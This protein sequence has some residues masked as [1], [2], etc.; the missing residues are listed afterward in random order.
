MESKKKVLQPII[1]FVVTT[2][3]IV[4]FFPHE[5][6]FLFQ[7]NEGKPWRY[8]T[9]MA[10]INVPIYKTDDEI[11]AEKDSMKRMFQP[12][13]QIDMAAIAKQTE[14]LQADYP[15]S[16]EGSSY[17]DEYVIY[18]ETQLKRVYEKGIIPVQ[19]LENLKK[20]G[21]QTISL[22]KNN[23]A[24]TKNVADLY[25]V[26]TAYE[27]IIDNAPARLDKQI[28]KT[29]NINRYLT[30]NVQ[31]DKD[32]SDK[33]LNEQLQNIALSV[34]I[35]QAGERIVD[36]GEIID[37]QTYRVLRS[38]KV[39]HETK[40]GGA[41]RQNMVWF[42]EWILIFGIM[43][44]G[45]FYIATFCPDIFYNRRNLI[46]TLS[47]I[48][49]FCLLSEICTQ[50]AIINI[51]VLPLAIVPIMVR[52]FF[53]SHKAL[54][55]HLITVMLCSLV[56][57]F[58]Y[59]FLLLQ[60]I[61]GIVVLFSLKE[62][63]QRSQ[64]LRC[65]FFI[66]ITY[67]VCYLCL[68][69]YQEGDLNKV[70]WTMLLFFGLNFILSML[71]Y[72]FIYLLEKVFGYTSSI[73]LVE[74]SNINT[75]ILKKLSETCPGT[76]QHSLQMS[77]LASEAA[78]RIKANTQLIRTGALYHDIG[79]MAHP[80][81]FTENQKGGVNPHQELSFEESAQIIISH[82]TEGV[83]MAEKAGLPKIIID[84]IRTHHGCGKTKYFYTSFRNAFPDQPINEELF[85][86]PGPNPFTKET[87]ILMMADSVEAASRSLNEYT[88]ESLRTLTDKIIDGQ[89][90]EGLLRNTPL[91]FHD[92]EVIKTAFVEKLKS[93]YHTRISYPELKTQE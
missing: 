73:T 25:T 69:L 85:T 21:K 4:Y 6:K 1:C 55:T 57:P 72:V 43:F 15:S 61:I 28:L 40:T 50:Y 74:L 22:L 11:K 36:R 17:P 34:G 37:H 88:E 66:F 89:I 13:Y 42:G 49:T 92:V 18:I 45:G 84:F 32:I 47:G 53:D 58:P 75:P 51:Y 93:M 23:V 82:V 65:T 41:Q 14:L 7:F 56:A 3:L 68:A 29:Y 19:Q 27:S 46:F 38:L 10:P 12:Y 8:E 64:L 86:Y 62:L 78:A 5:G 59:E 80:T 81:F 33:I 77:I 90:A 44:C 54:I 76:F 48:L 16:E 20:E 52:V 24:G 79:K 67:T 83:K 71:S 35:V 2:I 87:G 60:I 30:E 39:I 26:K 63:T 31:Y 9:L 70:K 91:T